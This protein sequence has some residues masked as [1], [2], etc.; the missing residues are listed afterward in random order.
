MG[1][2][3]G[4]RG[5]YVTQE[6]SQGR[7]KVAEKEEDE[8][9]LEKVLSAPRQEPPLC[10]NDRGRGA[11]ERKRKTEKVQSLL[12]FISLGG[13]GVVFERGDDG[14]G[15]TFPDTR[16][17]CIPSSFS[18]FLCVCILFRFTDVQVKQKK[19]KKHQNI[20]K[21]WRGK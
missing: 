15:Q 4:R 20:Y 19:K 5:A 18:P 16:F 6:A 17:R 12:S 14:L 7:Q 3:P 11:Q 21:H 2:K 1:V 13:G 10:G 9:A 8:S